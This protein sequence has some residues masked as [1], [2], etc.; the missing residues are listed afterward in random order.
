MEAKSLQA[1]DSAGTAKKLNALLAEGFKPTLAFVF[2]SVTDQLDAVMELMRSNGIDVFGA[3]SSGEFTEDGLQDEGI[4]ILFLDVNPHYYKL[5]IF[6]LETNSTLEAAGQLGESGKG[7]FNNPGFIVSGADL[8][9]PGEDII[10]GITKVAGPNVFITGGISGEPVQFKGIVFTNEQSY[11]QGVVGL[12]LDLDKIEIQGVAV[13]GW[14]TVGTV[15]TVTDAEDSWVKEIDH[16]PALDILKK[17][18]GEDVV[19]DENVGTDHIK[20]LNINFPLQVQRKSGYSVMRPTLLANLQDKSIFCGG[21]VETGDVF[22]FSIPP[23]FDVIDEVI[24]SSNKIKRSKMSEC[25]AMVIF[26]CAGRLDSFGPM[27]E[28]ELEGLAE[29]WGSPMAGFFCL[30]EFGKAEGGD[31]SEFHG[32]TCSWI[33]IKEK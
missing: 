33:S 12:I 6:D 28:T 11:N 14:K 23:D 27:I 8:S 31:V 30:G 9:T 29:T 22:Q 1:K 16:L 3:T 4:S 19:L 15:K 24:E 10:R 17:Y 2:I 18:M 20:R 5:R 25:D 26:S 7:A 21:V 13:S 32:S